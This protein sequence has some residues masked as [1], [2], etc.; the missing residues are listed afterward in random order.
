MLIT[1]D[2]N[3]QTIW[4]NI[5]PVQT[6]RNHAAKCMCIINFIGSKPQPGEVRNLTPTNRTPSTPATQIT[7]HICHILQNHDYDSWHIRDELKRQK[8]IHRK[9]LNFFYEKSPKIGV[10]F[11]TY[12]L[13]ERDFSLRNLEFMVFKVV[14]ATSGA[15]SHHWSKDRLNIAAIFSWPT[16]TIAWTPSP[17]TC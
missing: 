12:I 7:Y 13:C 15:Q 4:S 16:N 11:R 14:M 1:S 5:D 3:P 6:T 17:L 8:V 10:R 9:I 2:F